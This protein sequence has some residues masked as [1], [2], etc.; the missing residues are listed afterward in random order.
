MVQNINWGITSNNKSGVTG[1]FYDKKSRAW[2]SLWKDAGGNQCS[3]WFNL[4]KYGN[5]QACAM[6]MEHRQRAIRLLL[7]GNQARC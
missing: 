7:R 1:V 3:K 6:A 5:A 4:K 2:V